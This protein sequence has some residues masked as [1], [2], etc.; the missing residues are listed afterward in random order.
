VRDKDVVFVANAEVMPV[1]R[2]FTALQ[3]VTG[4][5]VTGL[6]TCQNGKC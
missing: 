4:P 5:I 3:N 1:Y 2:A 6:L